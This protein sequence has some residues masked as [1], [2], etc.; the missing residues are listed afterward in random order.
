ML[1]DLVSA[2]SL[3]ATLKIAANSLCQP[4]GSQGVPCLLQSLIVFED[5]HQEDTQKSY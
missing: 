4:G 1:L 3:G 5:P 2:Y